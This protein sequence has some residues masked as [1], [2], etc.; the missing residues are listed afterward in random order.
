MYK[1]K[2]YLKKS[3]YVN[4][5]HNEYIGKKTAISFSLKSTKYPVQNTKDYW[6]GENDCSQRN[7]LLIIRSIEFV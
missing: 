2:M 6:K 1:V 4:N 3:L 5:L 7:D